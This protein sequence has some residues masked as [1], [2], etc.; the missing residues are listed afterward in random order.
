[1]RDCMRDEIK[2]WWHMASWDA[3]S[4][5]FFN[6]KTIPGLG[7]GLGLGF[8]AIRLPSFYVALC[9]CFV[10]VPCIFLVE[11]YFKFNIQNINLL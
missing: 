9:L 11:I 7:L 4:S 1:M 5:S 6:D 2:N 3:N 10:N 8:K